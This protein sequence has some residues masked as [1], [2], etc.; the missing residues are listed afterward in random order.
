MNFGPHTSEEDSHVSRVAV[1]RGG[2]TFELHE[3]DAL[4]SAEAAGGCG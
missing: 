3:H 1:V 2:E 4:A